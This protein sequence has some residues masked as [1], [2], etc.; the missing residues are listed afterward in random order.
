MERVT[1]CAM[2]LLVPRRARLSCR[3]FLSS[4]LVV[5]AGRP[6]ANCADTEYGDT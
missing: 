3:R 4:N 2:V 1:K 5:S 6:L